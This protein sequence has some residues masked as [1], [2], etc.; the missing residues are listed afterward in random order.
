MTQVKWKSSLS[1]C[2]LIFMGLML[3]NPSQAA[4]PRSI[5]ISTKKSFQTVDL[6][7]GE[8]LPA[9][10]LPRQMALAKRA[11]LKGKKSECLKWVRVVSSKAKT[12]R[13]WSAL[14]ELNCALMDEPQL[15]DLNRILSV[16]RKN[17][18]WLL[19]GPSV[20]EL[21]KSFSQG[22]V[23]R[24]RLQAKS[25]RQKAWE[26]I[27]EALTYQEWMDP[28]Q[29]ADL[30]AVAGEIS[31]VNQ[32]LLA[33]KDFFEKSLKIKPSKELQNRMDSILTAL[34]P[35]SQAGV[36]A[37]IGIG[38]NQGPSAT[39]EEKKIYQRMNAAISSKDFLSAIS[40]GV[41]LLNQF[42]GGY[43]AEDVENQVSSLF[44]GVATGDDQK[45]EQIKERTL[46]ALKK[47]PGDRLL[48][49]GRLAFRRGKYR[50]AYDLAEASADKLD[51]EERAGRAYL[52][53]AQSARSSK[54]LSLAI[55]NYRV[56]TEKFTG[57]SYYQESLFELGLIYFRS[58]K[59]SNAA[60]TFE[61]LL[62]SENS[63]DFEYRSLYWAWRSLK[64]L[65]MKRS[66]EFQDLLLSKYPMT[67]YGMQALAEKNNGII[68]LN[69]SKGPMKPIQIRLRLFP[70]ELQ[71]WERFAVLLKGG[72]LEEAQ[73]ELSYLP[74]P[75]TAEEHL[76]YS[77]LYS[78]ARG[79]VK[80]IRLMNKAWEMSPSYAYQKELL[81]WIFP[82]NFKKD[83]LAAQKK[84]GVNDTWLRSLIRQESA[85]NPRA[86]SPSNALGL[87]QLLPATA[88]E[89]A[90]EVGRG[91]LDLPNDLF[92]ASRNI[93]LGSRYLEKMLNRFDGKLPFALAAYNAGPT[94]LSR[95]L[96]GAKIPLTETELWVDELPWAETSLYVKAI[97]RNI[98]I[99]ELLDKGQL[100]LT[101]PIW[102]IS[103]KGS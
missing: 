20:N 90:M 102:Q 46:K 85:F 24:A 66:Q 68:Q 25:Q 30:Y 23:L 84:T 86:V 33:A 11:Y 103:S 98:L 13:H 76:V 22:L 54:E 18:E 70:E 51:N 96:S 21:R 14:M 64:N 4:L 19:V 48:N 81:E 87:M 71:A 83:L 52:L 63:Q 3:A 69:P 65:E 91:P 50:A 95:W 82:K 94:R 40:D 75:Q 93:E 74:A 44:M 79:Y 31:F 15:G 99:Y 42:P 80:A 62:S 41:A 43:Y 88:N 37:P 57:E 34:K 53:A 36:P 47:A 89:V 1:K 9:S 59:F 6:N 77:K 78:E 45:W 8:A 17:P 72:W 92:Q 32:D 7:Q 101:S 5:S 61:K 16:F 35:E 73:K 26:F 55:K 97:L 58:D 100:D 12:L 10:G 2:G 49:W 27:S 67:L 38:F 28:E 60:A 29:R 39:D 56:L